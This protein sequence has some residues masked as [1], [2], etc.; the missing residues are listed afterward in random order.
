MVGG[1]PGGLIAAEV[2]ARSGVAVTVYDRMPGVARKLIL[3][4]RGG[5]N[6]THSEDLDAFLDRYGPARARLEPALRAWGPEELRSW[7]RGLGQDPIVGTSGRVFPAGFRAVP[8]LR[9]WLAR[10][11]ALGV[12]RRVRH[13][14]RGWAPDGTSL[15]FTAGDGTEVAVAPAATLL[16][17]GGA[18]WPRV[19]ADGRWVGALTGVGVAV[20]P[21]RPA[22]CGFAVA[23]SERF[24]ERFA[25]TPVKGVAVAVEGRVARGDAMVTRAG[26]EGGPVYAV[27]G[28]ARDAIDRAGP[29][30]VH[31]DLQPDV[32]DAVLARRLTGRPRDS[33]ATRLRRAGLAP[34]AAGLVREAT[35]NHVPADPDALARLVKAL[36]LTLIAPM[37]IERAISSAGGIAWTDVDDAFMLRA[38]PGVFVAG[39]MLDWEAPTGGYLLQATF[40]TG[41][42]AAHG[43]LARLGRA[44]AV[45]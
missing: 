19:G 2:L 6:L 8:L 11:D 30:P 27:S 36:P 3:A 24:V 12:V 41:V 20:S 25:G 40:S 23:W 38:R 5:L 35:G 32:T 39:E 17:L 44:P 33:A 43:I 26:I 18:S 10:L 7:C 45:A 4:G 34:V 14:W 9:A 31:L 37:P 29:T 16:A 1:G 15:V 28:P 22:N 13:T 42:A 21:L